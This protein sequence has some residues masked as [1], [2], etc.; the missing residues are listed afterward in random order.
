[1]NMFCCCICLILFSGFVYCVSISL[2]SIFFR[3]FIIATLDLCIKSMTRSW[4]CYCFNDLYL[5]T[6]MTFADNRFYC[7]PN[8]SCPYT[9]LI[10][11]FR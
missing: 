6:D 7:L 11:N 8:T 1:M 2:E 5:H 4:W 10:S 9:R 3:N